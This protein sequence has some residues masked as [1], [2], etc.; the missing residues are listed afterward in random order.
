M[1]VTMPDKA[2]IDRMIRGIKG[3]AIDIGSNG[4]RRPAQG[5]DMYTD[6]FMPDN[7]PSPFIQT[8]MEDMSMFGDKEFDYARCHHVIEHVNDPDKACSEM[9]RIAKRGLLSFPPPQ[10]EIMFGRRDHNWFVFVDRG[11]L[12]FVKKRHPSYG[13]ERA[14]TRCELNVDFYWEG[15]FDWQ[16]VR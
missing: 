13:I 4:G 5:F 3:K 12:L 8:P 9:I 1:D 15:S 11:R 10:A 14:I 2:R 7:S 16:V 6:I